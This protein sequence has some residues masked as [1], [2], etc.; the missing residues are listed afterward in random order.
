MFEHMITEDMKV[1]AKTTSRD[2]DC[3]DP[4]MRPVHFR[5]SLLDR[6]LPTLGDAMI[7]VWSQAEIPPACFR[8]RRTSL[9]T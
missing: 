2:D 7:S 3:I 5:P 1:N 8:E 9:C 6:I 4:N